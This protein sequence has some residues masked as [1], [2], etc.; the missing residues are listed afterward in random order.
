MTKNKA[1]KTLATVG[2]L[3]AA[4]AVAA[5]SQPAQPETRG[6][7]DPTTLEQQAHSLFTQPDKYG[8]AARLFVKAAEA[9]DVGDPLRLDDFIMASRLYYYR[10]DLRQALALMRQAAEEA[11]AIGD[12]ITAA[13]A[14]TDGAFIGKQS[15]EVAIAAALA[16][17]AEYL[18]H[19][20]LIGERDRDEIRTR[21]A[22]G[23]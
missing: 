21:I 13:H 16:K 1:M 3:L 7:T 18:T 11:T 5:A 8:K 9:R 10:G 23:I 15:G 2:L 12:V 22:A 14:F 20:P 19:S 17:K 6:P 4:P